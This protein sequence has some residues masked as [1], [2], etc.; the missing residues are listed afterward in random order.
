MALINLWCERIGAFGFYCE[1][2]D[3]EVQEPSAG[4]PDESTEVSAGVNAFDA[5]FCGRLSVDGKRGCQCC[6]ALPDLGNAD[7]DLETVPGGWS[8]YTFDG[9]D[10]IGSV[11]PDAEVTVIRPC[12]D[13]SCLAVLIRLSERLEQRSRAQCQ[14]QQAV[15]ALKH[16]PLS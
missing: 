1:T 5:H 11:L 2:A 3:I 9:D 15:A 8:R 7:I 13:P 10:L 14:S 12:G 4:D 6:A 16:L